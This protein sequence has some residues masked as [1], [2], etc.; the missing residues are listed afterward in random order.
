MRMRSMLVAGFALVMVLGFATFASAQGP[1][2]PYP[3]SQPTYFQPG[4]TGIPSPYY[5]YHMSRDFASWSSP[6]YTNTW[7]PAYPLPPFQMHSYSYW[8]RTAYAP[9]MRATGYSLPAFP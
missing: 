8:Y 4:W 9:Y 3:S 5:Y 1:L 7:Q 2:T 6:A